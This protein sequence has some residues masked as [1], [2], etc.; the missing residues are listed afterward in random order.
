MTN[1][2]YQNR[3][4]TATPAGLARNENKDRIQNI[5]LSLA[6]IAGDEYIE[7][8]CKTKAFI[9]NKDIGEYLEIAREKIE[10]FPDDFSTRLDELI[11][12][13]TVHGGM[14]PKIRC[15]LDAVHQGV[16]SSHIIDGRVEHALLLEVFTDAGVGTLIQSRMRPQ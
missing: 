10:F 16:T 12:D 6:D 15:A 2:D 9:E 1:K 8:I 3:Y 4:I 7:A 11:D 5:A 13:G 14:L